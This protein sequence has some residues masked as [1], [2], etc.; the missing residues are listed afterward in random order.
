MPST[1]PFSFVG[2]N[3]GLSTGVCAFC[4][5]EEKRRRSPPTACETVA[6]TAAVQDEEAERAPGVEVP[7][8]ETED[9]VEGCCRVSCAL[10]GYIVLLSLLVKKEFGP[11]VVDERCLG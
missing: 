9:D 2:G 7:E 1:S 5:S 10:W 6:G 3:V 8:L 4:G 11:F